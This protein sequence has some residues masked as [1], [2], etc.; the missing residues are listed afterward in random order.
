MFA[1][2]AALD[3]GASRSPAL[4]ADSHQLAHPIRVNT[5]KWIGLY[6]LGSLIGRQ[7]RP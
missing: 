7:E 6:D 4:D 5:R 1:A 2:D 3:T